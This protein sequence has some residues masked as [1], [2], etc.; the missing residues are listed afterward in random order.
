M[1]ELINDILE[2]QR[3]ECGKLKLVATREDVC[4][5]VRA[6]VDRSAFLASDKGCTISTVLPTEPLWAPL[7][8]R[9]IAQ[10]LNNLLSNALKFSPAGAPVEVGARAIP[11]AVEVW[12]RDHGPGIAPSERELLFKKFSRTSVRPTR[13]EKSTGLG[14]YIVQ[15][16]LKLHGG[17]VQVESLPGQGSTFSFRVPSAR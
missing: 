1:F 16:I 14:L 9:K 7:D 13:G 12:V 5:L 17:E 4:Q 15:E 10:V 8:A 11:D 2:T 6:A 3:I